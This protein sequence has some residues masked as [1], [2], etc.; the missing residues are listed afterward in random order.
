MHM[1]D[2]AVNAELAKVTQ[3]T[4]GSRTLWNPVKNP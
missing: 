3:I 1:F 2:Y 4:V